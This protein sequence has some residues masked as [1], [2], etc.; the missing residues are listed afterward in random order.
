MFEVIKT[1][2]STLKL[3]F[4]QLLF[5]C[6]IVDYFCLLSCF[7][8]ALLPRA[9][10]QNCIW[11]LECLVHVSECRIFYTVYALFSTYDDSSCHIHACHRREQQHKHFAR[12]S[13]VICTH[14]CTSRR[15]TSSKEY[16]TDCLCDGGLC[17]QQGLAYLL[18]TSKNG[19]K[20]NKFAESFSVRI[21]RTAERKKWLKLITMWCYVIIQLV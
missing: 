17:A 8:F 13:L 4:V 12:F 6:I 15:V 9:K 5:P 18:L 7:L 10:R 16:K 20:F 3:V 1:I 21:S 19:E 14:A 11:P 2:R